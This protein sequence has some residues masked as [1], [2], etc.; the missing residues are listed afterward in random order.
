MTTAGDEVRQSVFR[1]AEDVRAG[2]M[3]RDQW[4]LNAQQ[5][6]QTSQLSF[7]DYQAARAVIDEP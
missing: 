1:M 6:L 7:A 3:S 2:R 5:L 4:E